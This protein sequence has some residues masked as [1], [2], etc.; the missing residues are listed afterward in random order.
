MNSEKHDL[1]LSIKSFQY[2]PYNK[3]KKD[4]TFIVNKNRYPTP[5]IIADILSPKVKRLHFIDESINEFAFTT[6]EKFKEGHFS[7][8]LKLAYLLPQ[9]IDA[10]L[11]IEYSMYFKKLGNID[12]YFRLNQLTIESA[13]PNLRFIIDQNKNRF[14]ELFVTNDQ[15]RSIISFISS[16]FSEI[17]KEEM[18]ELPNEILNE[19][20]SRESLKITDEDSLLDFILELY[21]KDKRYATLLSKV[22]FCNLN[23]YSIKKFIKIFSFKDLNLEIWNSI[24]LRLSST[25]YSTTTS[26]S[27]PYSTSA[28]ETIHSSSAAATP[29]STTTFGTHHSSLSS[30]PYSTETLKT[31][32]SASATPYSTTASG[33]PFSIQSFGMQKQIE[34]EIIEFI[35]KD[36]F[37]G[38]MHYLSKKR[39][40]I[41][42]HDFKIIEIT[43]NSILWND[44]LY[45]PKNLV[46]YRSNSNFYH[47]ENKPGIFVS[48]DFKDKRVQLSGYSIQSHE[49]G[50]S[51]GNLRNWVIEVSNDGK[52]WEEIDRHSDAPEL[53]GSNKISTFSVQ[54]QKD[55][56]YRF[57]RLRQTGYS[58]YGG[59]KSDSYIV[60]FVLIEFFGKLEINKK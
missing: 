37:D 42:I 34:K 4:F 32:H 14:N 15:F 50:E 33:T 53:N 58:W 41:N 6:E 26:S 45:H 9:K 24:C 25:P 13:I 11:K 35:P 52:N 2:I 29:Y 40:N 19:I 22:L 16:H 17:S 47:S 18:S 23:E 55:E 1:T 48:F 46:D 7:D 54:Q 57:V 21:V 51:Q 3:Y 20:I 12:E 30:T 44:R 27:T 5:R 49:V 60:Y 43:S 10:E 39:H 28:L 8:F 38:I 31:L 36:G 56:F 59:F